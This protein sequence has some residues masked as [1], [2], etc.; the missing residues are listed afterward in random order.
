VNAPPPAHIFPETEQYCSLS[1]EERRFLKSVW[2][3][4]RFT[5]QEIKQLIDF[6]SDVEMWNEG[7]LSS[8]WNPDL[9]A[10]N[11]PKLS[12][13]PLR[14]KLIEGA[15]EVWERLRRGPKSYDSFTPPASSELGGKSIPIDAPHQGEILGTC[16]VASERTRC[17]N[18]ETL[19]VVKQC[20]FACSY[21]SIQSF[22]DQGRVYFVDNLDEKLEELE[23]RFIAERRSGETRLRHIG[24]GQSSDSLMWGNRNGLLEKLSGF[25]GRNPEII[26]ELKTKSANTSWLEEHELPSN[27]LATWSLNPQTIIDAEEHLTSSLDDR[28]AAARRC[29][30]KGIAVGFHF[31]P[32]VHYDRWKQEYGNLFRRVQELFL[33][34]EVVTISLGTLTFIRPVI[35][36]LRRRK[37]RSKILQMPLSDAEG[38]QSYPFEIK[39]ELFSYAYN[40][41]SGAWKSGVFFYLCMEEIDLWEPVFGR[42]YSD[43]RAFEEDMK[44]S[45]RKKM[46]SIAYLK[47][48]SKM[49]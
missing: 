35:R 18:L 31:H 33:P 47:K 39:R 44:R 32:I 7:E 36:Q 43:N 2:A 21:C 48:A 29:A 28:L 42:S 12:G 22:Y 5:F 24:T 20:G 13:K 17:C 15:E 11:Y 16:P 34:E 9:I 1:Y 49:V 10:R 3:Q 38:K 26:L 46:D 14:R 45:Y 19:D 4:Y 41:F 27:M 23:R 8:L 6:A 37:L 30:D 40:S 25:A